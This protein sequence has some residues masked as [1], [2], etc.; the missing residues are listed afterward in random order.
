VTLPL[1][2]LAH[3]VLVTAILVVPVILSREL[4][5]LKTG[6]ISVP[7]FLPRAEAR[8]VTLGGGGGS[9]ATSIRPPERPTRITLPQK[10]EAI[11][12][13]P[14]ARDAEP[15]LA[16]PLDDP[17]TG[18]GC[19]GACGAAGD[20]PGPGIAPP[21]L[22]PMPVAHGPVEAGPG[23]VVRVPRKVRHVEPVYPVTARAARVQGRVLL[24]CTLAPDGTVQDIEVAEGSAL[25]TSAA[26]EAVREWRYM[27]T[28][29]NGVPVAVHLTV[30]VDF[31]LS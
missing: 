11:T 24:S 8:E 22:P 10:I 15:A 9:S 26:V 21:A 4:P 31:R 14:S 5:A 25:L 30:V 16:D 13:D 28:L 2:A 23:G 7:V 1:S 18:G 27:P 3:T 17:G 19:F 6:G 12:G 29:L 20:K